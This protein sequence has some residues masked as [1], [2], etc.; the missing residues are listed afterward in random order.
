[1]KLA[2]GLVLGASVLAGAI[3]VILIYYRPSIEYAYVDHT[4]T[5]SARTVSSPGRPAPPRAVAPPSLSVSSASIHP[6]SGPAPT[7]IA[8]PADY[9][10]LVLPQQLNSIHLELPESYNRKRTHG[11]A[12]IV[13]GTVTTAG[14]VENLRVLKSAHPMLN[15]RAIIATQQLRFKPALLNGDSVPVTMVWVH[16]LEVR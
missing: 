7:P 3:L 2:L 15:E 8:H 5:V 6:S 16:R 4:G 14:T 11:G 12:I 1:M 10:G 9:P 13:E